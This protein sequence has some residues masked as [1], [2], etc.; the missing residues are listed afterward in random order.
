MT[1]FASTSAA[2]NTHVI[3]H[4]T[5][6]MLLSLGNIIRDSGLSMDRFSEQRPSYER[7]IKAWM[8]S[9]HLEKVLLEVFDPTTNSLVKRWD[10]EVYTDGDGELGLWCDLADIKY[11]LQKAGRVPATCRYDVIVFTKA[12]RPD[13]HGWSS[14]GLRDT[15][16]LQQI[17]LGTAIAAGNSGARVAY[18]R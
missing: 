1:A 4:M 11:H 16:K 8:Q 12:G 13:V 17:S 6:K 7:A 5:D 18:W 3:A 9:G 14:C 15:S 2:T 10:L